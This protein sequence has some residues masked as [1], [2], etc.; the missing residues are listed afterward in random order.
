MKN[1]S[2][3]LITLA[4]KYRYD[5][6]INFLPA[7]TL[8]DQANKNSHKIYLL[9]C[10]QIK[11]NLNSKAEHRKETGRCSNN[12]VQKQELSTNNAGTWYIA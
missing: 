2:F 8:D 5:N 11:Y 1:S 3:T 12:G 10:C 6:L 4:F 9:F 7:I